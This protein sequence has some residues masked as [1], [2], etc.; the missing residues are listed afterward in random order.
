MSWFIKIIFN[1]L[2]LKLIVYVNI[3]D[4]KFYSDIFYLFLEL[5][6]NLNTFLAANRLDTPSANSQSY[7]VLLH[8]IQASLGV[9]LIRRPPGYPL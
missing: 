7:Q 6:D 5:L 1:K 9:L 8:I 2:N 3:N 4:T